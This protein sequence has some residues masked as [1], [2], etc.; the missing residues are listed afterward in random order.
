MLEDVT[1]HLRRMRNNITAWTQ[2]RG[3]AFAAEFT[4]ARGREAEHELSQQVRTRNMTL[5]AFW[6]AASSS[7]SST[8]DELVYHSSPMAGWFDPSSDSE[9]LGQLDRT[10]AALRMPHDMPRDL[11]ASTW[12]EASGPIG[13][14]GSAGVIATP[15]Y[16]PSLNL[17]LQLHGTKRWLLW[18]PESL[19]EG[20]LKLH[21]SVHPSRRQVRTPLLRTAAAAAAVTAASQL[22]VLPPALTASVSAGQLLYVP[23]YWTHAVE[24]L[25]PALSLS[26]LSPSWTEAVGARLSWPKLPFGRLLPS[27]GTGGRARRLTAVALYLRVLLPLLAPMMLVEIAAATTAR[28]DAASAGVCG[29]LARVY[30]ARHAHAPLDDEAVGQGDDDHTCAAAEASGGVVEESVVAR[31]ACAA[32][33][34]DPLTERAWADNDADGGALP[35]HEEL[36][37][38]AAQVMTHAM[39]SEADGTHRRLAPAVLRTLVSDLIESLVAWA[40]EEDSGGGGGDERGGS[41]VVVDV[42]VVLREWGQCCSC[43]VV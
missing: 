18:P 7:S 23:P 37:H 42:G 13:W 33:T 6:A 2:L 43:T 21:S 10:L 9:L 8:A 32:L 27:T 28:V 15:H 22:N 40:L 11:D 20:A 39:Y 4:L 34:F 31:G 38:A 26:V 35:T 19:D 41:H 14:M 36:R 24:S 29:M 3:A 25:T 12:P 30:A 5:A 1:R 16:D 17:V